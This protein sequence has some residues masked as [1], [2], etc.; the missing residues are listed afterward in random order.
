MAQKIAESSAVLLKNDDNIL[1]GN[2]LQNIGII[3]RLAKEPVYQGLGSSHVN[4]NTIDNAYDVFLDNSCNINYA[5]GYSL[6]NDEIDEVLLKESIEVAKNKDIVYLFIGLPKYYEAEGYDR[7]NLKLPKSHDNLVYEISKVNKNIVVIL[8]GGSVM[9]M[10]WSNIPKAILLTHLSGCRGGN[11]TVNLLLGNKNPSGKL[12][13]TYAN[14]LEDYPSMKFYPGDNNYVEYRESIFVGYRYFDS[15]DINVKYPFGFGLSYTTF[16]YS[17]MK[18][19]Y[20]NDNN[21]E[22]SI[23][24]TNI[25]NMEGK[26]VVQLYISCLYSKLFRAKQELKGFN[27]IN[28]KPKESKEVTFILDEDC[29]AYYN[30]QSHQYEVEEGRYGI[31][32][33]SSCRHIKFSTVVNKR[34]NS[35][36]TIDYKAKS[37]SYYEIYKNKLNPTESE[38]ENIYN[39]KLP[40][41]A[42]Q[43]YPFTT[44]STINDIKNTY[45]GDLIISAINKK[46]YKFVSG[47]KAM[48]ITVKESLNDQPFRLMAMVTRGTINRKSIQGFV[49][50]LN[51]HYIKGFLQILRNRK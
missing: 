22:V 5:D 30:I 38:F 41:I 47:D 28:L 26:E 1:P 50:L 21:M 24:I 33:G 17:N 29:F 6:E 44:N 35:V 18:I 34:G 11:A 45:G 31:S 8:Q 10:P 32:I 37:P 43:I 49:D 25:G 7:K 9:E 13:E 39:K 2:N 14:I 48:E 4:P 36:K 42:N 15:A 12:S 19:K 16:E 23:T 46:A 3:G 51:K 27:K 40:I 20:N